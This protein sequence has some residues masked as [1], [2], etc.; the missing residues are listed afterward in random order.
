MMASCLPARTISSGNAFTF[1]WVFRFLQSGLT[2][3]LPSLSQG[4]LKAFPG[5]W[6]LHFSAV[7][8]TTVAVQFQEWGDCSPASTVG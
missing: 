3:Q 2:P 8:P 4:T 5:Q 7:Y 1:F 6:A